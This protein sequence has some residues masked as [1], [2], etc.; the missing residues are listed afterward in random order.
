MAA[1]EAT[2]D[3]ADMADAGRRSSRRFQSTFRAAAFAAAFSSLGEGW[4]ERG[5]RGIPPYVH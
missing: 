2:V 4:C 5:Y 1:A 3:M